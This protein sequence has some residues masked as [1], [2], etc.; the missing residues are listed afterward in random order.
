MRL[1]LKN[2]IKWAGNPGGMAQVEEH[3]PRKHKTPVQTTVP[4]KKN[5]KSSS[6]LSKPRK[7]EEVA[8]K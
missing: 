8:I 1:H 7:E 2:K 4:P 5:Y 6:D 3:F